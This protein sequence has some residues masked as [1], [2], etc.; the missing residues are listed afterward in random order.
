MVNCHGPYSRSGLGGAAGIFVLALS[1]IFV[2][3]D[4][5][6]EIG[7]CG[8]IMLA[9]AAM[10]IDLNES[11]HVQH[12]DSAL[13]LRTALPRTSSCQTRRYCCTITRKIG[14]YAYISRRK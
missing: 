7:I 8:V 5:N 6:A 4:A 14:L 12:G 10:L 3:L 13:A 11:T 9:I 1:H 2:I